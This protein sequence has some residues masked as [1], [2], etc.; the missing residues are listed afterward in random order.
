[1]SEILKLQ[2][3]HF[4]DTLLEWPVPGARDS[5]TRVIVLA[6]IA[7]YFL[8]LESRRRETTTPAGEMI[9]TLMEKLT[10]NLINKV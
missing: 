6:P 1:M 2:L 7:D 10:L 8:W 3:L 9:D 4:V 5:E